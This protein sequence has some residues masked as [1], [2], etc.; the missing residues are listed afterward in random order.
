MRLCAVPPPHFSATATFPDFFVFFFRLVCI[1]KRHSRAFFP[2]RLFR[3]SFGVARRESF[4][5]DGRPAPASGGLLG[6]EA[7]LPLP[8]Q[9]E[10]FL[11][12]YPGRADENAL[13][14]LFFLSV[15]PPASFQLFSL[16]W[17]SLRS[18]GGLH[19]SVSPFP[20]EDSLGGVSLFP[21]TIAWKKCSARNRRPSFSLPF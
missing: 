13:D 8:G 14:P 16:T 5:A 4:D 17:I 1:D 19:T 10:N 11:L 2:M 6:A 12:V 9:L 7:Q 15:V 3:T 21:E 18:R 20:S